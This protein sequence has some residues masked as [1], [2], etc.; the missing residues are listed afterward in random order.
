MRVRGEFLRIRRE[1]RTRSLTS[2]RA[3]RTM[4]EFVDPGD[5]DMFEWLEVLCDDCLDGTM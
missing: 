2:R 4:T 5:D 3:K 1:R